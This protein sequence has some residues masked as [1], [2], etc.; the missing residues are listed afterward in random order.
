M[1][2]FNCTHGENGDSPTELARCDID[3]ITRYLLNKR[4]KKEVVY[5][6]NP[7]E[8]R[9]FGLC[10]P[11]LEEDIKH[12]IT[13]VLPEEYYSID[14]VLREN[15][16]GRID[17]ITFFLMPSSNKKDS[18]LGASAYCIPIVCMLP[19][20]KNYKKFIR[21]DTKE[22]KKF[23]KDLKVDKSMNAV[24]LYATRFQKGKKDD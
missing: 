20:T 5:G 6:V 4:P 19:D 1:K 3:D 23:I 9:L 12:F 21:P 15:E 8:E 18:M 11:E 22:Y 2:T 17:S 14:E 10:P 16:I 7:I 13:F 24:H